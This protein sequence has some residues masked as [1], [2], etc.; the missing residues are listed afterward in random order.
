M[1]TPKALALSPDKIKI[2]IKW[3]WVGYTLVAQHLRVKEEDQVCEP[4]LA[5]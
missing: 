3:A 4:S 2:K 1:G 5:T